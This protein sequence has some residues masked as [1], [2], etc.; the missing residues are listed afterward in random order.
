MKVRL[1]GLEMRDVASPTIGKIVGVNLRHI[2]IGDERVYIEVRDGTVEVG[3]EGGIAH[4][5]SRNLDCIVRTNMRRA[6]QP[7]RVQ[8]IWNVARSIRAHHAPNDSDAA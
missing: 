1:H 7:P 5:A 6:F 8:Q 4:A 3:N 2:S